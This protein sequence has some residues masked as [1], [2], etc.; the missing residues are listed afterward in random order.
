MRGRFLIC[1]FL[2]LLMVPAFTQSVYNH[3][4]Q[5]NA[6]LAVPLDDVGTMSP[7]SGQ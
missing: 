7:V 3:Q 5:I 1:F 4:F 6:T 2:F